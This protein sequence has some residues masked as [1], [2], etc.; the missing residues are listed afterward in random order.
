MSRHVRWL[1]LLVPA[2]VSLVMITQGCDNSTVNNELPL[3]GVG[4]IGGGAIPFGQGGA[5]GAT[6][7]MSGVGGVGGAATGGKAGS[8]SQ[9]GMGQAG[10]GG[11]TS[12]GGMGQGGGSGGSGS[13]DMPA[14]GGGIDGCAAGGTAK[15]RVANMTPADLPIDVCVRPAG[16]ADWCTATRLVKSL[17]DAAL[18]GVPYQQMSKP[19][20]VPSGGVDIKVIAASDADCTGAGVLELPAQCLADATAY[21]LAAVEGQASLFTSSPTNSSLIA[22]RFINAFPGVA[23]VDVGIADPADPLVIGLPV[24]VNVAYAG[25]SAPGTTPDG[26]FTINA[27]GYVEIPMDF[28]MVDVAAAPTGGAGFLATKLE[29][30]GLGKVLTAFG[31]GKMGDGTFPPKA[32]VCD[33][34]GD[35]GSL[36][37]CVVAP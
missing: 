8:P 32:V 29:L 34:T 26:A 4:P 14:T 2:S 21:T 1:S 22:L 31:V 37:P 3:P 36:T 9:G 17:N 30:V 24:F 23:S 6:G 11:S 13:C 33:E 12:Q 28:G 25:T 15:I 20:D 35:G 10:K 7:G 18:T 19:I 5:A 16:L 27:N